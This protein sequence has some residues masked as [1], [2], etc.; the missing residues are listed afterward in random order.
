LVSGSRMS[1]VVRTCGAR[2]R[3]VR[4]SGSCVIHA[5]SHAVRVPQC[6]FVCR[7]MST[8]D[9]KLF[10]LINTHVNKVNSSGHIF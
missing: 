10:S 1:R 4:A 3:V 7:A 6:C 9:N 2:R 8:C 5:L